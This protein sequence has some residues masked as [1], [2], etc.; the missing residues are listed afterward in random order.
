[1]RE[2]EKRAERETTEKRD[3]RKSERV[4]VRFSEKSE[5]RV[6]R[7]ERREREKEPVPLLGND[8]FSLF[9]CTRVLTF[10]LFFSTAR[11]TTIR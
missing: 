8:I 9:Q 5:E 6:E 11:R 2:T 3:E 10:S 1:V 4:R 7:E